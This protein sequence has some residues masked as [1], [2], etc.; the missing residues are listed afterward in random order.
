MSLSDP[1][2]NMLTK[3]RNGLRI[4]REEV[5]IPLS[6]TKEKIAEILKNEGF[7][8]DYR[9]VG[10]DIKKNIKI[11]LKYGPNNE[12][13]ITGLRRI[14]KPSLRVYV[15]TEELP[16]VMGGLGIAIISTSKG[17]MTEKQSRREKVGGEVICY[18]W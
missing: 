12:D 16:R 15:P 17:I 3:I 1:I 4:R 6:R 13:I 7:I 18:V 8:K 2:A 14:S 9:V 10:K 5:D 11:M